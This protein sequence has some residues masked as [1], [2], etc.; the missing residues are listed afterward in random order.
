MTRTQKQTGMQCSLQSKD[1][2][3]A[4]YLVQ[5]FHVKKEWREHRALWIHKGGAIS[6]TSHSLLIPIGSSIRGRRWTSTQLC[7]PTLNSPTQPKRIPWL[8]AL[9]ITKRSRRTR[10]SWM[11]E[12]SAFHCCSSWFLEV[13]NVG[14]IKIFCTTK[15]DL[16]NNSAKKKYLSILLTNYPNQISNWFLYLFKFYLWHFKILT[17]PTSCFL[18]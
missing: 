16:F 13:Q 9:K 15:P 1:V 10:V 4:N 3:W 18:C 6:C 5:Q 2:I 12:L 8:M 17:S 7:C 11:L 14:N